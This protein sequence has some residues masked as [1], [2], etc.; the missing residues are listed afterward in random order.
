MKVLKDGQEIEVNPFEI[1]EKWQEVMF[2]TFAIMNL[3]MNVNALAI[4]SARLL[5]VL[6]KGHAYE[7][8][9]YE[10]IQEYKKH[11]K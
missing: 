8:A 6:E 10:A 11:L 5:D 2:T 9:S 7:I 3:Q 1:I 4:A